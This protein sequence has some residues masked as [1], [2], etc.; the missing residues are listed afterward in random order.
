MHDWWPHAVGSSSCNDVVCDCVYVHEQ[1]GGA[2]VDE[3][4]KSVHYEGKKIEVD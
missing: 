1:V 2:R 3:W 4:F